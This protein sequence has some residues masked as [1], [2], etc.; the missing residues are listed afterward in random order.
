MDIHI[1]NLSGFPVFTSKIKCSNYLDSAEAQ[2]GLSIPLF[3]FPL[4][5]D[6]DGWRRTRTTQQQGNTKY[7]WEG[8][9]A[10]RSFPVLG[11]ALQSTVLQMGT[12]NTVGY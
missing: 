2:F 9:Q 6:V 10:G 7:D 11:L 3:S 12:F 4:M 1:I 8:K 5:F